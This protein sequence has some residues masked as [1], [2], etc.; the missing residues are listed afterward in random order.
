MDFRYLL[1][2]LLLTLLP[3]LAAGDT[4]DVG[5]HGF[6]PCVIIEE[7]NPTGFEIDVLDRI[8]ER[9]GIS[10]NYEVYDEFTAL[11]KDVE[12]GR[13]DMASAGIS[14]TGKREETMDFT[15][16]HMNSGLVILTRKNT[17]ASPFRIIMT[18]LVNMRG[19]LL[20]LFGFL[21]TCSI[22]IWFFERGKTSFNDNFFRGVLDGIYWVNTTMS[23]VGYGDKTPTTW[24][25]KFFAVLVM[26]VGITIVFPYV[27][28]SMTNVFTAEVDAYS[29][30]SIKDLEN[31]IVATKKGSTAEKF[32]KNIC[33]HRK[34]EPALQSC[35]ENLEQGT[36][37]AVVFD[38]P[39]VKHYLNNGGKKKCMIV[40][41]MFD[42]QAYGFAL[43]NGSKWRKILNIEILE[44]MKTK[45]FQSLY[46][47][48]FQNE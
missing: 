12:R 43:Q 28:A 21:L 38:M 46:K 3:R 25:G 32:I 35:Y 6:P 26:W 19:T 23:T 47:K 33:P 11:L 29:I 44:F 13:I 16:P 37:D 4:L 14:I 40:G 30:K 10:I 7:G 22:L 1:L 24:R 2:I 34:S 41:D 31:R 45:E 27:V 48:W 15:H 39:A 20:L 36:V 17:K 18:Y 9:S 5:V 42:K 8:A